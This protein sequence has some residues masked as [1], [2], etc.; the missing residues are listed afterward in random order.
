MNPLPA[1]FFGGPPHSGKSVLIHSLTH[2]LRQRGVAHYVLRA[3][4]DGEGDWSNEADQDLVRNLRHK[5][6]FTQ[7]F[8]DAI[9]RDLKHRLLP[10]LVDLGGDLTPYQERIL[11]CCTHA[12]LLTPDKDAMTQWR[13]MAQRHNI[14]IVAEMI[15]RLSGNP[16][17]TTT[18][19]VLRGVITGLERGK[20]AS[21]LTFDTLIERLSTILH[22]CPDA[23][24]HFHQKTCPPEFEIIINLNRL[25]GPLE[26]PTDGKELRWEPQHLKKVLDYLPEKTPIALY[27]RGTNWLYSAIALLASP[28]SFASFDPRLGWVK[29]KQMPISTSGSEYPI[30]FQRI[31]S[32]DVVRIKVLKKTAHLEYADL[33][34]WHL[35]AVPA[36]SGII[37]RGKIPQWLYTSM[38]ITYREAPWIGVYQPQLNYNV[39][40]YSINQDY[41]IGERIK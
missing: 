34:T 28:A 38:A 26:I 21:S 31:I 41:S 23:L 13:D 6:D 27:G 35:P 7:T 3:T 16:S 14:P 2:A 37:L 24:Y 9:C 15:S 30:D 19:P 5:G 10:L 1:I 20:T 29:A 39:I 33:E 11:D 17:I 18:E 36:D 25:A 8:T 12:V 4:P 40:V 32:K 22:Q